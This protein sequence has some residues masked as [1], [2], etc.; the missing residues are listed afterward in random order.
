VSALRDAVSNLLL[1]ALQAT[2]SG[3]E[4][5]LVAEAADGELLIS[6]A[7]SGAGVP[8]ELRERIWEPFFTTRQR[9]TGLGLAIVR[10]RVQEVGGSASLAVSSN[11]RG[12]VFHLRLPLD[13]K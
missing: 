1:N 9:G 10:K 12:A 2:P 6:V 4:V 5:K 13:S 7:D 3:G 11:G 8:A